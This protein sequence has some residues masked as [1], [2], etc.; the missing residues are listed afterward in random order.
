MKFGICWKCE[1]IIRRQRNNGQKKT[2][3]GNA[4]M[5]MEKDYRILGIEEGADEREIKRAYFK[6]VRKYSPEK[7]PERFQEIRA[8]YER[9]TEK[10]EEDPYSPYAAGEME[11]PDDP[12]AG[13]MLEQIRELKTY[14][15]YGKALCMAEEGIRY[16]GETEAFLFELARCCLLM[17]KTG[18]AVKNFEKLAVRYPDKMF[19]KGELAKAY[20]DRGYGKK[21]L[22][23]FREAFGMGWREPDF[24]LCYSECCMY[25]ECPEE[26]IG[27]LE[28]MVD[29]VD[30]GN[31]KKRMQ[32]LLEAHTGMIVLSVMAPERFPEAVGR[33]RVFLEDA[34]RL[35]TDY[36]QEV[37][38]LFAAVLLG[39]FRTGNLGNRDVETVKRLVAGKFPE[40]NDA[41]QENVELQAMSLLAD[42]RMGELMKRTVG[43]F[44][45]FQEDDE[46]ERHI[47]FL[48]LDTLLC[49]LQEWP[50]QK[51]EWE[52][53]RKE[54]KVIYE[55]LSE[56]FEVL[57][58]GSEQRRMYR[59]HVEEEY[60]RL[61]KKYGD[62]KYYE[63]YPDRQPDLSEIKWDSQEEGTFVRMEK[64][65]GRND[66]CPCGSGK[67]YKKC[68]MGKE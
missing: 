10:K 46:T 4:V 17:G 7:E 16:F 33:C 21:A 59:E 19:Y 12:F 56:L 13:R 45:V 27:I 51:P 26:G 52:I 39:A 35:L 6:L 15:D 41:M 49:H 61:A 34:E 5:G 20:F 31:R 23:A 63:L 18:K 68:C 9:L 1:E 48:Q 14:G 44:L 57:Q 28:D 40:I 30:A 55:E 37:Q 47:Y 64:K 3:E 65:V 29:H 36:G 66:P 58:M 50:A 32:E 42:D 38:N 60:S 22:E 11:M 43:T 53:I 62:G 25:R 67:K 54:Y 24:I 8:A 2:E